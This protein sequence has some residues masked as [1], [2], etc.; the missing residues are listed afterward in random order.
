MTGAN[1]DDLIAEV[2]SLYFYKSIY[3]SSSVKTSLL[4]VWAKKLTN[5]MVI[6]GS[7]LY[8]KKFSKHFHTKIILT[9]R[10][11]LV[12]IETIS[13]SKFTDCPHSLLL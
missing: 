10:F 5:D 6:L 1:F 2:W 12:A 13:I 9:F 7:M 3:N 8:N 4:S 11:H